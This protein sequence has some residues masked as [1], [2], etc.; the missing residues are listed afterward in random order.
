MNNRLIILR[1]H[2]YN[3][4]RKKI[5]IKRLSD[6]RNRNVTFLKRKAGLMKKAWELSVLCSADVAVIVFGHNG[7]LFEFSS[8]N[9]ED[10]LL[11]Y[12]EYNGTIDHKSPSEFAAA[13]VTDDFAQSDEDEEEAIAKPKPTVTTTSGS[14]SSS[15]KTRKIAEALNRR[16]STHSDSSRLEPAQST[17][18]QVSRSLLSS[19]I[20]PSAQNWSADQFGKPSHDGSLNGNDRASI[21]GL[22]DWKN[23]Q[24]QGGGASGNGGGG[25]NDEGNR[26]G[27]SSSVVGAGGDG[28]NMNYLSLLRSSFPN[29]N[30]SDGFAKSP[31]MLQPP[32]PMSLYDPSGLSPSSQLSFFMGQPNPYGAVSTPTAAS[33]G[34][35]PNPNDPLYSAMGLFGGLSGSGGIPSSATGLSGQAPIGSTND[36]GGGAQP[37]NYN[38][39][40]QQQPPQTN[41]PSGLSWPVTSQPGGNTGSAAGTGMGVN[42]NGGSGA[43]V[44]SDRRGSESVSSENEEDDDRELGEDEEDEEESDSRTTGRK[45][46]D[47]ESD[48]AHTLGGKKGRLH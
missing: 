27:G 36:A 10:L 47:R 11:K 41:Y 26:S 21:N 40:Q 37:S 42:T 43:G 38:Q 14:S 5:E 30:L 24:G 12:T 8:R 7:K 16:G 32:V 46:L 1:W 17:S 44:L 33:Q 29:A 23:G 34:M 20:N 18:P 4:G 22:R 19:V 6:D 48:D 3:M 9:I 15:A 13:A 2:Q 28:P 45:R 39:Q 35:F 31:G 25:G